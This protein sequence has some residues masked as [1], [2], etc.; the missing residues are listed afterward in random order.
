MCDKAVSE[1]GGTLKSVLDYYK[2]Q[3]LC[4][5]AVDNYPHALPFVPE[6]YK[7]QK[8]C[9]IKPLILTLLQYNLLMNAIRL[10]KY[11]MKQFI[12]VFCN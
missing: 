11:V 12:D 3:Q 5:K 8:K 7:L 9:V 6:Y 4:D 10:N 2:N 1:N